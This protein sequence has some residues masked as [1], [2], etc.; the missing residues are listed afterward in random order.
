[1]ILDL[2]V[3]KTDDG[4]DAKVP[5]LNEAE[6]WAHT[7]DEAIDKI[8]ELLLFYLGIEDK[9]EIKIDLAR[10]ENNK[11]IYKLVFNKR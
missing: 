2:I 7:E 8:L 11:T 6:T 9:K 3:T 5:S 1:M 10:K 4:F